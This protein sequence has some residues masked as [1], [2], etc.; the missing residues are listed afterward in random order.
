MI[1]TTVTAN[2]WRGSVVLWARAFVKCMVVST[3]VASMRTVAVLAG[4][5]PSLAS[6]ALSGSSLRLGEV[7]PLN[8]HHVDGLALMLESA[9]ID[10]VFPELDE[11]H[12]WSVVI[13]F[14]EMSHS[15][16][17]DF[18]VLQLIDDVIN[19]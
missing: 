19:I 13:W 15:C 6:M 14:G 8:H 3:F 1:L 10:C 2:W 5:S 9:Q 4:M 16:C 17:L 11:E 12:W 7:C 18:F